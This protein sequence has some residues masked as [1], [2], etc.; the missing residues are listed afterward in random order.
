M[1]PGSSDFYNVLSSAF[2]DW[3]V[4][5]TYGN[6]VWEIVEILWSFED[7][8]RGCWDRRSDPEHTWLTGWGKKARRVIGFKSSYRFLKSEIQMT[9]DDTEEIFRL[10][11]LFSHLFHC[12]ALKVL[13]LWL[14]PKLVIFFPKLWKKYIWRSL[15][16][17]ENLL[18]L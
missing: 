2:F 1:I 4:Y 14:F 17:F 10:W 11:S 16:L 12:F 9:E 3:V 6:N 15:F 13:P 5:R 18:V 8:G 7:W